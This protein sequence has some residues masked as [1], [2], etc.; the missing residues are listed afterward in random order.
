[1]G[2]SREVIPQDLVDRKLDLSHSKHSMVELLTPAD[3]I[4]EDVDTADVSSCADGEKDSFVSV[5]E[6]DEVNE[7]DTQDDDDERSYAPVL[8]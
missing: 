4:A 6:K 8:V 3:E 2:R 7:E 1:M 5:D